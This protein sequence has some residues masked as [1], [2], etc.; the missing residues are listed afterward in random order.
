MINPN[1]LKSFYSAFVKDLRRFYRLMPNAQRRRLWLVFT[2][3]FVAALTE[4]LTVFMLTFFGLSLSAS[5]A[6][7]NH[8][9]VK[10]IFSMVP[11]LGELAQDQRLLVTFSAALVVSFI[12][13]KNIVAAWSR[14]LNCAYAERVSAYIGRQAMSHFLH[15]SYYWHLSPAS[16]DFV[17]KMLMR[18]QLSDFLISILGF[19]SNLICAMVVFGALMVAEPRL[20]ALVIVIFALVSLS[21]YYSLRRRLDNAGQNSARLAMAENSALMT[22]QKAVREIICFQNQAVFLEAIGKHVQE[23]IPHQRFLNLAPMIPP[24]FLEISGFGSI[25]VAL[26]YLIKSGAAMPQIVGSVSLLLLTAW[27]VLPA[28]SR[29]MGATVGIRGQRPQALLCLELLEELKASEEATIPKPDP[30]FKFTDRLD[31]E[32]AAFRYPAGQRDVLTDISLTIR[33]GESIG[34]IGASGAGKST[35]ALLLSGLVP[36]K[37][38]RLLVDGRELTPERQAALGRMTGFVPQQPFLLGGTVADNVAFSRWSQAYDPA[39]VEEACRKAAM[40]FI[41]KT[42]EGIKT[43]ISPDGSGLSG[44]QTQRLAIARALFSQP[45][46]LIMD[47]A[48]SALDQSNENIIKE[49]LRGLDKLI[50][51]I[52]IAHRLTTVE[53]CDRVFWLEDGRLRATGPPVEILPRYREAMA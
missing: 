36:L 28:V 26:L 19:Y 12:I 43:P 50:T 25:L 49:T 51:V 45:E 33:K 42:P 34:L 18:G 16:K 15:K 24:W 46:L 39:Q 29:A 37:G 13:L 41:F 17:S 30:D 48:T 5:E 3:Q 40:D 27:R 53:S 38:G 1:L 2:A 4:S 9:L 21:T 6:T 10:S 44:G 11:F 20:T 47:E 7:R 14:S 22:A 31:L 32:E 52:I 35:L 23:R 8:P